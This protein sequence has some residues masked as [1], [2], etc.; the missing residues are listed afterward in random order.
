M[1]LIALA[2]AK[3][4]MKNHIDVYAV[5]PPPG[6]FAR[7]RPGT[8]YVSIREKL[9]LRLPEQAVAYSGVKTVRSNSVFG[10]VEVAG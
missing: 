3:R 1:L 2:M 8:G 5:V 7:N 4:R 9:S 10:L 6:T